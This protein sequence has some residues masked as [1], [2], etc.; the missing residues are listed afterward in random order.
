MMINYLTKPYA[1]VLSIIVLSLGVLTVTAAHAQT[2]DS[3]PVT[4]T[5][6]PDSDNDKLPDTIDP[7]PNDPNNAADKPWVSCGTELKPCYLPAPALVRYG[8]DGVYFYLEIDLSLAE[9]S[10]YVHLQDSRQIKVNCVN[11]LFGD[12]IRVVKDCDYL[13]SETADYDNDNI[14]DALDKFPTNPKESADTDNDGIGDNADTFVNDPTNAANA[15]WRHCVREGLSCAPP[16]PA[17]IRYGSDGQYFF[18]QTDTPL[19][20]HNSVF[21]DPIKLVQ[22]QCAYLLSDTN[23]HDG[24]GVVDNVDA[25]PA[26]KKETLDSDG[27]G[28]GDNSDRIFNRPAPTSL[29]IADAHFINGRIQ[30]EWNRVKASHY[31]ILFGVVNERPQSI[32]HPA[33]TRQSRKQLRETYT[34]EP[35]STELNYTVMVEAFDSSG[36]SYFSPAVTVDA[37]GAQP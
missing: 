27:D 2:N 28:I 6:P 33:N 12:P 4:A 29:A 1:V 14:V 24:D 10:D 23:D 11:K 5:P 15:N 7:F 21:G 13:L 16:V 9:K 3:S 32:M 36:N 18:R 25:L 20:C 26:N 19:L 34:S 8:K 17:I 22:K 31:K 35:L 30:V 37:I